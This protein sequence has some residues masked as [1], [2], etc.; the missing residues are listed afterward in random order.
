MNGPRAQAVKRQPIGL[1]LLL[2]KNT[3]KVHGAAAKPSLLVDVGQP[4]GR[5]TGSSGE[6]SEAGI[7]EDTVESPTAPGHL[8]GCLE[9]GERGDA[10]PRLDIPYL[11]HRVR[12]RADDELTGRSET[13]V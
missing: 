6:H 13:G 11:Q 5:L 2:G 9:A 8:T 10:S 3:E 4:K 12:S 7:E 1:I